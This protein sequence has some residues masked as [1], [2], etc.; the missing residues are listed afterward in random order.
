M[1]NSVLVVIVL[2]VVA[3]GFGTFLIESDDIIPH[4]HWGN[5][6][7]DSDDGLDIMSFMNKK[8]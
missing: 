2:T 3:C 6:Y 5:H 8:N 7:D 4:M 1:F